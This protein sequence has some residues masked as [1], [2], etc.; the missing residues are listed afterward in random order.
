M[1]IES[2]KA[3]VERMKTDENFRMECS[4]KS[5][6]ENRMEFVKEEWL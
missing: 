1:S 3:F 6:P 2:A 5:S 4:E